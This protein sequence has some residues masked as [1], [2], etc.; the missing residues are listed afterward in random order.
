[1]KIPTLGEIQAGAQK[2]RDGLRPW[3]FRWPEWHIVLVDGSVVPMKYV[4]GLA[5]K[6]RP[7][8]YS[9]AQVKKI[10]SGLGLEVVNTIEPIRAK[11]DFEAAVRKARKDRKGRS[12]RLKASSP[13]P[14]AVIVKSLVF[15][16]NP[17]V[18]AEVLERAKGFC[19]M[20]RKEAPFFRRSDGTPY[21]EVHHRVRLA[22]GG[23]DAVENAMA[24]CPNC[25]RSAH[26]G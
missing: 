11:I 14:K 8:D 22:D 20:C 25:H 15:V 23:T 2:Y 9:T 24:L 16:R 1:M 5:T 18:V 21:L 4:Y 19:E 3:P 6:T 17:D 10:L 26:Y 12:A 7:R 13:I